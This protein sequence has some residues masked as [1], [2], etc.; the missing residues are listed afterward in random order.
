[1]DDLNPGVVIQPETFRDSIGTME[2]HGGRKW[3]YPKKPSGKFTR[4]RT[5]VSWVLLAFL[6]TAPFIRINGNPLLRFNILERE[7]YFFSFPFYT[8][9]FYLVAIGFVTSIV[10]IIVFTVIYGRLFCGWVCPQTIFMEMVFRKIEYWIDGDRPKQMKLDRQEWNA[11]KIKKRLLKWSIFALISIIISHTFLSYIIGTE[12]LFAAIKEGPIE[13]YEMFIA[14]TIFTGLFYFVFAWFREQACTLVCPYGRLQGVLIDQKTI[15]VT[16]DFVRGEGTAGR[17][18][19]RKGEDRKALGKGDC[20]DCGQCVVVC[21]T[22]ID[23]RNGAQLECVN[24][25]A[26][27][28][29]CDEVM[30]KVGLPKGLIRYASEDQ[31]KK[32]EKFVFTKRMFAYTVVLVILVS[33]LVSLIIMRTP[34]E[35][36]FLSEP[37]TNYVVENG[38]MYNSYQYTLIN[39]TNNDLKLTLKVIRPENAKIE[40]IEEQNPLFVPKKRNKKGKLYIY[41]PEKAVKSSK[42]D[43][44]VGVYDS[45]G[46]E[47]DRY[48]TVFSG[49]FK[50]LL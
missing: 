33:V 1:M 18:P 32:G 9:D 46:K 17:S 50:I 45:T 7:F 21:P 42:Q 38:K 37:G 2:Q 28:D 12:E 14:L 13:H 6:F 23:I 40:F 16:Y 22:G 34:V 41:L 29:A 3:I 4:Y 15:N 30:E 11:D 35:A 19:W 43:I 20:I 24:C 10:F 5:Y 44:I 8:Q 31:I 26:C 36:K 39:K 25:T 47:M 27:I 48:K 49:P